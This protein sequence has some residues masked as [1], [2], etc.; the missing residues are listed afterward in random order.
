VVR[1]KGIRASTSR[2]RQDFIFCSIAAKA[3]SRRL[4]RFDRVA[5]AAKP[6]IRTTGFS[7][8][9]VTAA[10]VC[11]LQIAFPQLDNRC[12]AKIYV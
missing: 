9:A 10:D 5:T 3:S 2:N 4:K 6:G 11:K 12:S 7:R 8:F 1:E